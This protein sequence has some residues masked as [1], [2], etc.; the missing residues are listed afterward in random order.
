MKFVRHAWLFALILITSG[1]AA[2][3][4]DRCEAAMPA[5]GCPAGPW[6][7]ASARAAREAH[8]Q[9]YVDKL[10]SESEQERGKARPPPSVLSPNCLHDPH[11]IYGYEHP[12][13]PKTR[14]KTSKHP[15][16]GRRSDSTHPWFPQIYLLH[17]TNNKTCTNS[18]EF[19]SLWKAGTTAIKT[20]FHYPPIM[21]GDAKAPPPPQ[22]PQQHQ[23][24]SQGSAQ[25][26][27]SINAIR[28]LMTREPMARFASGLSEIYHRA[29]HTHNVRPDQVRWWK[30][31]F[32][33]N[34]HAR[35]MAPETHRRYPPLKRLINGILLDLENPKICMGN[36]H[37]MHHLRSAG[38]F[39]SAARYPR[40]WTHKSNTS[41]WVPTYDQLVYLHN[42]GDPFVPRQLPVATPTALS[43]E[44]AVDRYRGNR[45]LI[46]ESR[47][48]RNSTEKPADV[49]HPAAIL[50]FLHHS[51]SR[52]LLRRVCR[53][54]AA[55]FICF[56][57]RPPTACAEMLLFP[58]TTS[59]GSSRSSFKVT[60]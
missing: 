38:M 37:P 2:V 39:Y 23:E 44:M 19:H 36:P 16:G 46:H 34:A 9:R 18:V 48:T 22:I 11:R 60:V 47:L 33:G 30:Y 56:G 50:A 57:W 40:P 31:V 21:H 43:L 58:T 6:I 14:G 20:A 26:D 25:H 8:L 10:R 7:T 15:L 17:S 3:V 32:G 52:S 55:D 12:D 45:R 51:E 28:V 5:P 29:V 27:D 35:S 13:W 49:P 59:S 4:V 53:I 54:Y 24:E 1:R 42:R 41:A